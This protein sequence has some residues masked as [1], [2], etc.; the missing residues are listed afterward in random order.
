[1]IDQLASS[2]TERLIALYSDANSYL[3]EG[4]IR[5]EIPTPRLCLSRRQWMEWFLPRLGHPEKAFPAIHIAGTSGKGSVATMI[6]EILRAAN[7]NTGLHVSP[8]LQVATEKL[9]V[10]GCY[11]SA[12]EFYQLTEWVKPCAEI[13]RGEHVPMHGMASVAI[14][15]EYFRRKQVEVAVV[16]AGVG[17][18]HDLTRVVCSRVAVITSVGWD[19]LK[20]LGPKLED[21]AWHKVGIIRPGCRAIISEGP[22]AATAYSQAKQVGAA[23]RVVPQMAYQAKVDPMGEICL[24]YSS[25]RWQLKGARLGMRGRFQAANAALAI[26]AVEEFDPDGSRVSRE[27]I[28]Q[29]LAQ[30][31]MPA[32]MEFIPISDQNICP[33]ILDGAHNADKLNALLNALGRWPCSRLHVVYGALGSREPDE[34]LQRLA[35]QSSS[36]IITEPHVYHKPARTVDEIAQVIKNVGEGPKIICEPQPGVALELALKIAKPEDL[37]VITGSIYLCGE[38]RNKWHPA[39]QVL[40]RRKSW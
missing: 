14:A 3:N 33:V 5:S 23:L 16:E 28:L 18:R 6:A 36:F 25:E 31:R 40:Q 9:W 34:A 27:A 24:N 35:A 7:Y 10:N 30:A 20:A 39:G 17:G 32:R 26:A 1:M 21:I 15:L 19:H 13:C 4:L 11:A 2:E 37:V 38:M 29:G 22:F 8:Y 12:Q